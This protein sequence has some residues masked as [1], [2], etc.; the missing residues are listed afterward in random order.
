MK[1]QAIMHINSIEDRIA[2]QFEQ[3]ARGGKTGGLLGNFAIG[4]F[5][6]R[7]ESPFP[8]WRRALS[9][10]ATADGSGLNNAF[11]RFRHFQ[12]NR[13]HD[14]S[15]QVI[16]QPDCE[17]MAKSAWRRLPATLRGKHAKSFWKDKRLFIV[18]RGAVL[19]CFEKCNNSLRVLVP[20]IMSFASV[21]IALRVALSLLL[22]E[23]GGLIIHSAGLVD[24]GRAILFMGVS[25]SGKSTF[26]KFAEA[27]YTLS[28]EAV[29]VRQTNGAWYAFGTPFSGALE[30]AACNVKARLVAFVHLSKA[31]EFSLTRLS[32]RKGVGELMKTIILLDESEKNKQLVTCNAL[33]AAESIP[34]Y[35]LKSRPSSQVW[36]AVL[37]E[38]KPLM[39]GD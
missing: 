22:G 9:S 34:I 17:A 2:E 8:E 35:D 27:E 14:L 28:D 6:C 1:G 18:M 5:I 7:I 12:T 31:K 24:K 11:A 13:R 36:P 25:G 3:L 20:D 29:I 19:G 21:D 26:A 32:S 23:T 39:V 16:A 4:D 15:C 10:E 33:A 30:H 38:L 37:E